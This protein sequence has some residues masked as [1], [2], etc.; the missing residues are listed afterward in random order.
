MFFDLDDTLY[1]NAW[2]TAGKLTHKIECYCTEECGL[3]AGRA[4]DL[5]KVHGTALA[6]LL[7]EGHLPNTDEAISGY[8]ETVHDVDIQADIQPDAPLR[9][10]ILRLAGPRWV[11]TASVKSHAVRCLSALGLAD[12]FPPSSIIDCVD[13]KLATKHSESAFQAAMRIA[14]ETDPARCLLLDDSV[15]NL[16]TAK[17][18]GWRTVLCGLHARD[19]GARIECDCADWEIDT[20]HDLE[21]AIPELFAPG[22]GPDERPATAAPAAPAADEAVAASAPP[23]AAG[24]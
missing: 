14:G 7:H 22:P 17:Q 15:A 21:H 2:T 1:K 8:L 19:G 23:D 6:G 18:L 3:P 24:P 20:V 4:Y 5:Y 9:E 11:F 12:L 13:V 16:R 10:M